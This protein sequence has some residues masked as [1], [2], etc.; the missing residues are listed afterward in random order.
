MGERKRGWGGREKL[1]GE[2]GGRRGWVGERE[3]GRRGFVGEK[4]V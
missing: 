4:R 2:E 3:G 1:I